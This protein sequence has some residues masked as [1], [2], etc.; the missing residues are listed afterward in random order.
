MTSID[1]ANWLIQ[2]LLLFCPV[3]RYDLSGW[4]VKVEYKDL[5]GRHYFVRAYP[6]LRMQLDAFGQ[7]AEC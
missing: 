3:K 1:E 4:I 2:A 7:K 5:F 6:E